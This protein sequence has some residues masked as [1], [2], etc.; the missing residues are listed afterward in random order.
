MKKKKIGRFPG[1]K[2]QPANAE[3]VEKNGI[4][5]GP[6]PSEESLGAGR[7]PSMSN[8]PE[9]K[10]DELKKPS[11]SK[12]RHSNTANLPGIRHATALNLGQ[13]Q[14]SLD[15][16]RGFKDPITDIDTLTSLHL[17]VAEV[18]LESEKFTIFY[19]SFPNGAMVEDRFG[20]EALEAL[21]GSTTHVLRRTV[22]QLRS[23]R[24]A[25]A[26]NRAFADDLV[27]ICPSDS[28]DFHVRHQLAEGLA[29]HISVLDDDLASVSKVYVGMA[30]SRQVPRIHPERLVY[31]TLQ[32][33]M[34]NAMDVGQHMRE[35]QARLLETS[36]KQNDFML[37]Y[38][39]IVKC[40]DLSIFGHEAL[41]RCTTRELASPLVLF[42]IAEKT[43]KARKLSRLLRRMTAEAV[44]KMPTGHLMFMNLHPDDLAD[45]DLLDPPVWLTSLAK[46]MVLEI[47]ERA[48]IDDFQL[49]RT[50]LA[51]LRE[52]GFVVAIDD[53]GSGYS[54]LNTVA[55][56]EPEIIKLDM[57]LMRGIEDSHIRRDLV[58]KMISFAHNIG[59][60][61]VAEGIETR[62]QM[63]VVRDLGCHLMQGF[64]LARPAPEFLENVEISIN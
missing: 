9:V 46:R 6:N 12:R 63:N 4:F 36:M 27:I 25:A 16:L 28:T 53:L 45:P 8:L 57:L 39:P 18:L 23:D 22:T 20:W 35:A 31:R 42:D 11:R 56:L 62:T 40:S 55:E 64:Y 30:Q 33:A 1:E 7:L 38:Q 10:K 51:A 19:V 15:N 54:A 50:R 32:R 61:V 58:G 52:V 21:T 44:H 3:D 60:Q 37:H 2:N 47:T 43:N 41:V 49:F 48:A 59:C 17:A 13:S 26:L 29:R 5:D 24:G 34:H 14:S